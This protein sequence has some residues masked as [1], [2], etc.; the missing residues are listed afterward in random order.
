LAEKWRVANIKARPE[1]ADTADD[2]DDIELSRLVEL[3]SQHR[4]RDT[5][6]SV[7]IKK[8]QKEEKQGKKSRILF[9][10]NPFPILFF[11]L[12]I[13]LFNSIATT[14]FTAVRCVEIDEK[15]RLFI[16]AEVECWSGAL[17]TWWQWFAIA[18]II[19]L[20]APYPLYLILIRNHLRKYCNESNVVTVQTQLV[21]LEGAFQSRQV[22]RTSCL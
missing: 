4:D 14:T 10:V 8:A 15:L 6:M 5:R 13:F 7:A 17:E 2:S 12:T 18:M 19:F 11:K 21:A 1:E 9:E 16:D 3:V 22:V 20:I